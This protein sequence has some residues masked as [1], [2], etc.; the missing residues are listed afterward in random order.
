MLLLS[1]Q[2]PIIVPFYTILHI[3]WHIITDL[4][5]T[6]RDSAVSYQSNKYLQIIQQ[7]MLYWFLNNTWNVNTLNN[8]TCMAVITILIGHIIMTFIQEM[9]VYISTLFI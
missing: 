8:N 5:E 6:L 3:T 7:L 4:A 2:A 9:S 1:D